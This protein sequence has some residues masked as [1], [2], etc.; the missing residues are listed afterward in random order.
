MSS[1]IIYHYLW[2]HVFLHLPKSFIK[3]TFLCLT[4]DI[5]NHRN[6]W[7]QKAFYQSFPHIYWPGFLPRLCF[8]PRLYYKWYRILNN[9][10]KLMSY[11][12]KWLSYTKYSIFSQTA[13][14]P[15]NYCAFLYIWVFHLWKWLYFNSSS[16]FN[17]CFCLILYDSI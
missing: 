9:F 14:I 6:L 13:K 7:L 10:F 16:P 2:E 3:Y 11:K 4:L 12:W 5:F 8:W 15:K 1:W 17:S